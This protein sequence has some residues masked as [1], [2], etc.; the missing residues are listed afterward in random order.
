M[1]AGMTTTTWMPS[2]HAKPHAFGEHS[3]LLSRLDAEWT[4]LRTSRRAL[5]TARG[6]ARAD[7]DHPL[8]AVVA[9]LHDLDEIRHA[10]QRRPGSDSAS[11][12]PDDDILRALVELARSDELAGRVVLQHLLPALIVQAR[13]YRSFTDRTDPIALVVPAAW[14]AIRSFDV[15]RRRYHI[16][17]SLVS[18]ATFQ[19]FRRALRARARTEE[20]VAPNAF[21][22]TPCVDGP[23]CALDEF[24]IVL[25]DARRAGVP[26]C[27]LDLLRQLVR[28]GSPG[29]VAR[30]RKVTPRT[31]RNHRDRAI[32]HVRTAVGAA[33]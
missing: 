24:V 23:T 4:H 29:V 12:R 9:D 22:A 6:W 11:D 21:A 2:H 16:A 18:D 31:I 10:T 13:R 17:S 19:A 8:A 25:H 26:S 3:D 28:V 7:P 33:A 14:L 27:D 32:E 1:V 30:Q 15:E 5:R 20:V